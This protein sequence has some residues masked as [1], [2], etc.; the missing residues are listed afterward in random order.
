MVL[1]RCAATAF[2]VPL[3][4]LLLVVGGCVVTA[5]GGKTIGLIIYSGR[6][7]GS[8]DNM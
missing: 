4:M 6:Y 2:A 5:A 7:S 3:L 8:D 1:E